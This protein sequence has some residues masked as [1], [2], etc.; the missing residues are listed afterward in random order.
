M[1][2]I[3]LWIGVIIFGLGAI[4]GLLSGIRTLQTSRRWS[5]YRLRQRYIVQARGS[6]LL[7]LFSGGLAVALL[8]F[9][10]STGTRAGSAA[11]PPTPTSTSQPTTPL[12]PESAPA[13]TGSPTLSAPKIGRA[14]CRE[15]V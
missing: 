3:A 15:R 8:F 11:P 2:S 9:A 13:E 4:I 6:V 14:S 12:P 1:S 5:D 10:R 7:A